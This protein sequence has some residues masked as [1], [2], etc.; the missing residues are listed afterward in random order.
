M[1]INDIDQTDDGI[2]LFDLQHD[3]DDKKFKSNSSVR[4]NPLHKDL[5]KL[6]FL[7][8]IEERRAKEWT[9][10]FEDVSK[11][12]DGT[13]S[14]TYSKRFANRL[15]ALNIKTKK[16]SFHSFR[17]NFKNA[18]HEANIPDYVQNFIMGHSQKGMDK[19]YGDSPTPK[20]LKTHIKDTYR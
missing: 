3:E 10:L 12:S 17:H 14:K 18:L 8:F 20:N 7:E 4:K 19:V 9:R 11:G 2:W 13:Y 5:M 16:T 6:G 1:H 15:N